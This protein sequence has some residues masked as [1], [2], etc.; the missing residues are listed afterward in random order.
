MHVYQVSVH[1]TTGTVGGGAMGAD[2]VLSFLLLRTQK[3]AITAVEAEELW[4][5][6]KTLLFKASFP[7]HNY[8]S[9][10]K[11]ETPTVVFN[12]E[13]GSIRLHEGGGQDWR[14]EHVFFCSRAIFFMLVPPGDS[15]DD[16]HV[17]FMDVKKIPEGKFFI[18]VK[19]VIR[20]ADPE[21][22]LVLSTDN[23]PGVP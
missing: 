4:E 1:T 3:G 14:T 21:T 13:A 10:G 15:W 9:G 16:L 7:K 2:D 23:G 20:E 18:T 11:E 17:S 8:R 6:I 12:A 19:V 22:Y 5:R